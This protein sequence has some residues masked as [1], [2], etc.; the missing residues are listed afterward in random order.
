M[1]ATRSGVYRVGAI[2]WV[3]SDLSGGGCSS[4]GRTHTWVG[5]GVG[6]SSNGG[7]PT[8]GFGVG[9]VAVVADPHLGAAWRG[10]RGGMGTRNMDMEHGHGWAHG[11]AWAWAWAWARAWAWAWAWA[12]GYGH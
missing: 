9:L 2:G 7:R 3:G 11:W 5:V 10:W 8:P 6:V 12:C 4:L 1:Q